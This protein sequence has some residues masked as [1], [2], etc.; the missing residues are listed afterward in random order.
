M[1]VWRGVRFVLFTYVVLH[2]GDDARALTT[3]IERP[4][5]EV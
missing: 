5:S 2:G 4:C 3:E 1:I